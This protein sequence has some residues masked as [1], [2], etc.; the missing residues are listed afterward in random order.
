MVEERPQ[1]SSLPGHPSIFGGMA[2]AGAV[3]RASGVPLLGSCLRGQDK[4][5]TQAILVRLLLCLVIW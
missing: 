3:R 2:T 1:L 4:D 5:L